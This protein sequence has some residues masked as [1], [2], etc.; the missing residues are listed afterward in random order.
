MSLI[1]IMKTWMRL[2]TTEEQEM[3][4]QRCGTSRGYL[5]QLAGGFR[6]AS[7]EMAIAIERETKAMAAASKGR[8]PVVYRTDL[9]PVCRGCDFARKC[10]GEEV[11][12]RGDFEP[13]KDAG[14]GS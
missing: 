5:Y 8:L 4:V 11:A 6:Q 14:G 13:V 9:S 2:A 3:L 1:T 7:A 10:L 12:V